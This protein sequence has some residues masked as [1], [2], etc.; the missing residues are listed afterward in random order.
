MVATGR[1]STQLA[2]PVAAVGPVLTW[3]L[4]NLNSPG[5]AKPL[6]APP[7][8]RLRGPSAQLSAEQMCLGLL[9]SVRLIRL[10]VQ[11]SAQHDTY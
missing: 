1:Q 9:V 7:S 8:P 6:A 2:I 11:V 10:F 5:P 4:Q 3:G